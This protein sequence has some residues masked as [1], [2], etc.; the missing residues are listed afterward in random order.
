MPPVT[1]LHGNGFAL[2]EIELTHDQCD[3]LAGSIPAVA[4]GRGGIR[5]LISHPSVLQLLQHQQLGKYLWSIVGRD[6]VAVKAT[7]FD[8]TST[9]NWRVR[10]HQDRLIAI[11]ERMDVA[12]YGPW[13]VK[14]GDLY[15]EPPTTVLDQMLAIR[16]YL[17]DCGSENGP[18]RV[19]PGSHE[20]GKLS[21][22]ALQRRAAESLSVELL[23]PK[24]A[25][26]LMRPLLIHAS[27]PSRVPAHRRVLHIELAPLE[28][29]SP[30]HWHTTIPLR[31][32]A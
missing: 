6:L 2:A 12:G 23:A 22:E 1:D 32:T 17:D 7:L 25:L 27:S 30:L 9:S 21:E 16:V 18:L 24:G 29:I 10:W 26:L 13:S 20:S 3:H 8:K 31:R 14:G 15:V 28:A 19:M 4:P 5:G 11:R